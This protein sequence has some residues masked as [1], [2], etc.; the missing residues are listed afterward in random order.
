ME[1]IHELSTAAKGFEFPYEF[2]FVEDGSTDSTKA[3]LKKIEHMMPHSRFIYHEGNKGRGAAIKSGFSA[4]KGGIIGYIDIDLEIGAP[5]I[6]KMLEAL[7]GHDVAVGKRSYFYKLSFHSIF[8]N[9]ISHA[10][11]RLSRFC[12][13]HSFADTETGFK[14][15][16]REK[17]ASII[18]NI[19]NDHWFWDTEFMMECMK[20]KLNV[21]EVPVEFIRNENKISTVRPWRDAFIYVKELIRYKKR[22]K[23]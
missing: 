23:N 3:Q 15:F 8:R 17:V 11:N 6:I 14:F 7:P 18:P 1:S 10:Y 9:V 13:K 12:L 22:Q 4:A 2:I 20:H 21:I 19:R 16:Y 5:F